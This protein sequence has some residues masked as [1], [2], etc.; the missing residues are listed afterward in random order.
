V[1]QGSSVQPHAW[2]QYER[3]IVF[4]GVCNFCNAFVNFVLERD[5]HGLFK[6]GTLQ[7]SPAQEIL[8]Q[9]QLSTD[10]YETFLLLE[11][12]K[13]FTKSTAALKILGQLGIPWSLLGV[14]MIIP[15]PIRDVI[16]DFIARHRYQWM[17]KSESCRVP[18]EEER[19]RFV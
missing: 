13:L 15:R 3:V 11:Q 2:G 5:S 4:D 10:D 12:G 9:F 8:R 18:T 17:G 16:Y 14:F 6:F 19:Q 1:K 7:S